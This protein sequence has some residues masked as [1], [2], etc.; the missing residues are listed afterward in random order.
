MNIK[1]A[2][3]MQNN[4]NN[5]VLLQIIKHTRKRSHSTSYIIYFFF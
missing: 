2:K 1:Y 4:K 5:L 3:R